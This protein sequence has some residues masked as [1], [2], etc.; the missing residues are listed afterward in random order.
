MNTWVSLLQLLREMSATDG[1]VYITLIVLVIRQFQFDILKSIGIKK[2]KIITKDTALLRDSRIATRHGLMIMEMDKLLDERAEIRH[3][4]ILDQQMTILESV[5]DKSTRKLKDN[6]FTRLEAMGYL[7]ADI[8]AGVDYRHYTAC[9]EIVNY[10]LAKDFLRMM[11]DNGLHKKTEAAMQTY[12]DDHWIHTQDTVTNVFDI[13]YGAG[14][15]IS[16]TELHEI[17][18]GYLSE[19][20]KTFEDSIRA[21]REISIT[22]ETRLRAIEEK[23]QYLKTRP[24][25]DHILEEGHGAVIL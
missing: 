22:Y 20:R 9:M 21:C 14:L 5:I 12:L 4:T 23:L 25:H 16:R 2:K 24:C 18:K 6:F 3:R 7:A 11:R 8:M 19:Y 1:L 13:Y 15:L 10:R 17:H